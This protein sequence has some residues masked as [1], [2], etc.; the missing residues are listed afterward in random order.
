MSRCSVVLPE[1][2]I[3]SLDPYLAAGGGR[4]IE[5]AREIGPEGVIVE[6]RRAGLRGRGGAGFP[7]GRKWRT[8]RNAPGQTTY[9]VCN[10]AEGEPGTFKD[11]AIL[12]RNPYQVVEGLAIAALAVDARETFI[13]LKASFA[14]ERNAVI[15]AARELEAAGILP[16]LTVTIVSGP[17]EYLF[18]EEKALLEVI[19]GRD[20]QPRLLP[21]YVHGLFATAPQLG[22]HSHE[23][24]RGHA[25]GEESNPTLVN[26]AETLANVTQI[27][28]HGAD[29][30]RT[31]GSATC[32]GTIVVTVVGDVRRP[33]VLEVE[34]G[35][36]LTEVITD[37]GGPLPG[38]RV[39]AVF[40]GVTNPVLPASRLDT[41]L[42]YDAMSAAGSGLG[43]AG[44]II[45]DDTACM[46]EVAEL[47]SRFL[48]V[49]S[50]GQCPPCKLGC[51]R[52]TAALERLSHRHGR[53]RD[54]ADIHRRLL[55]VGDG[56][57]CFLPVEEQ[58]V[59]GSLLATF[60]E[61]FVA[62]LEGRCPSPRALAL[63]KI[64]DL[65]DEGVTYDTHQEKKRPDWT[66]AA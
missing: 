48:W 55:V 49:E 46:V 6:L 5:R 25:P 62:H 18:G 50:C 9:A 40:S 17:E 1:Q 33:R 44:F 15:R 56:N 52:I 10:A 27:L 19:E 11:R 2:E 35:T 43:A 8:V 63:P 31:R 37:A 7:T 36:P 16:D 13:A 53:E 12:R 22:W 66:Y 58:Q 65:D 28:G 4:A 41:P 32:P 23:P 61:D 24:E 51:G 30:Y 57:R 42:T 60:P 26:N 64:V 39:K 14:R 34:L 38:R 47:F 29:W 59:V 45:Y 3:T 20:P 21:P 54:I